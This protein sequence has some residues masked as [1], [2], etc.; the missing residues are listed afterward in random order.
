MPRH[1]KSSSEPRLMKPD[2]RLERILAEEELLA[3][4]SYLY[5]SVKKPRA[6]GSQGISPARHKKSAPEP[7][8]IKTAAKTDSRVEKTLA[9]EALA[10]DVVYLHP[11]AKKPVLKVNRRLKHR[12]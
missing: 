6:K 1:R 4:L 3:D 8:L 9:E 12:I 7:R 2:P 11:S 10:A 5:G